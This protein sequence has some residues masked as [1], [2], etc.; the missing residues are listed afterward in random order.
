[1]LIL[2]TA[3]WHTDAN[4]EEFK[5]CSD[6]LIQT[7]ISEVPDLI[8][9]AGDV[10]NSRDIKLDSEACK[11]VFRIIYELSEVA[12]V[13]IVTGTPRHEG[14]ATE[15]LIYASAFEHP[16]HVST[17]PEQVILE[18]GELFRSSDYIQEKKPS[19]IIS[20][21]PTPTKQF[22]Q[23]TD[24]EVSQALTPVFAGFG[25]T[26]SEYNCPH[27]LVYHGTIAG[28][29][30]ANGQDMT[31]RDISIAKDQLAL[32]NFD[33]VACGHIHLPQHIEP[34]IYYSGSLGALNYGEDHDHGFYLHKIEPSRKSIEPVFFNYNI[35]S[36][37]IKTPSR[38][39]VNIKHDFTEEGIS[40][41][42]ALTSL[43]ELEDLRGAHLKISLKVYQDEATPLKKEEIAD[44]YKTHL[45]AKDVTIDIKHIPRE[46]VRSERVTQLDSLGDKLEEQAKIKSETLPSGINEI[47]A[48]LETLSEDEIYAKVTDGYTY[49][50]GA[51]I[52]AA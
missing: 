14:H 4:L 52:P 16:V 24:E 35:E 6:F 15:N 32:G 43:N 10:F 37:F 40:D 44:Y 5:K 47:A 29:T 3:D 18:S 45:G 28:A 46:V 9:I 12:A 23:S 30:L 26:A 22:M 42:N 39:L 25:A 21:M 50:A 48:D 27:I 19:A 11:E 17:M 36:R 2:H 31:G 34:N 1:M 38:K 7:A 41:I 33:L 8:I 20:M 49:G 13:A 51:W